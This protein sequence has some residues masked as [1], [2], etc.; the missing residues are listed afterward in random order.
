LENPEFTNRF[1]AW[2]RGYLT[3]HP[4]QRLQLDYDCSTSTL[5][6]YARHLTKLRE[7]LQLDHLSVTALA[8]WIE[9]PDFHQ[10]CQSVDE[11]APMFYDLEIDERDHIQAN[12]PRAMVSPETQSWIQKWEKCPVT[13]RAGLPNFQRLS[14]FESSGKLIGHLQ[15]WSP[16]HLISLPGLTP[17]SGTPPDAMTFRVTRE[18]RYEGVSMKPGQLLIWRVPNEE[19]TVRAIET[20]KEGGASG[21]IWFTHPDSTPVAWHSIPHLSALQTNENPSANFRHEIRPDGTI[22]LTNDG[23]GDLSLLPGSKP[24]QLIL[25][26][27][28]RGTFSRGD[29]G[30]FLDIAAPGSSLVRPELA[31]TITLS[32]SDLR[33]G[34]S[35]TS[36]P[37][38]I[39]SPTTNPPTVRIHPSTP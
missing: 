6:F 31:R 22:T 15:R 12:N 20:A 32:F 11:L 9:A 2:A 39:E 14:L 13:W 24:R 7:E 37:G 35:L 25:E 33:S 23:P 8:S 17:I 27:K 3:D 30:S 18:I 34:K 36:G 1:L 16:S 26:A 38:L 28:S 21:I 4:H 19:E 5:A 29:P 10:L